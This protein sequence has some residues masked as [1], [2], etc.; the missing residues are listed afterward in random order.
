[1]IVESYEDVIVLSGALRQNFWETVHT[2]IS[3]LLKRHPTGVI[4]DC[5]GISEVSADGAMTFRDMMDFIHR[6]HARIIVAAVPKHVQ[7]VLRAVPEV[8]SQLAVANSVE[9]ARRSLDL[10]VEEKAPKKRPAT[11]GNAIKMIIC[12]VGDPCDDEALKMGSQI[13]DSVPSEIHLVFVVVVPRNLPLTAPLPK[14]EETASTAL[15]AGRAFL[16]K[17]SMPH[18]VHLQR[19]RD[20]ASALYDLIGEVTASHLVVPLLSGAAKIDENAAL[21]KS[22]LTKISK[23]VIFVRGA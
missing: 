22:V 8:R 18:E 1:V 3:L 4:I 9:E 13:A 10:L 7:D 21:V 15:E 2:A 19:G 5:S 20:V 14:Q 6:H 12:L 17:R 23:E 16:R 11:P